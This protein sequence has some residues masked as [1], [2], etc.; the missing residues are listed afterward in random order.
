M[1]SKIIESLIKKV[2]L[3]MNSSLP[4]LK[5][6][7]TAPDFSVMNHLGQNVS[8]K[9]LL[10]QNVVLWFYPKAGTPGCTIQGKAFRDRKPSFDEKNVVVLGVSFDSVEEN[11]NFCNKFN[12]NF[13]L[14][15]D[16][17]R[18]IGLAYGA[19]KD[20]KAGYAARISY[21]ID[22]KGKIKAVFPAVLPSENAD[23]ILALL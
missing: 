2:K 1:P 10:G 5:V 8:L 7:E 14:L 12:F 18:E 6:G 17:E 15:C 23:E 19:C 22:K 20:K 16:I 11:A 13:Q 3:K 4:I 21:L 9:D